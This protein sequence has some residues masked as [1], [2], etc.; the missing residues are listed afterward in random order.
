LVTGKILVD[1][2]DDGLPNKE[3]HRL[4]SYGDP[5]AYKRDGYA[6]EPKQPCYV[7]VGGY[8]DLKETQRVK[9]SHGKGK[10]KGLADSGQVLVVEFAADDLLAPV[11]TTTTLDAPALGDLTIDGTHF[12]ST[13]PNTTSVRLFGAGV[14]DVT[15]TEAAIVA[16]APGAVSDTQIIIDSTL[17]PGLAAGDEVEVIADL[18]TSPAVVI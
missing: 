17:A 13:A 3:V 1:D 10:I 4:G 15:L 9:H 8:I 2:I 14:G 6:N 5:K 11:I 7:P 12:L 18:Q 16:V